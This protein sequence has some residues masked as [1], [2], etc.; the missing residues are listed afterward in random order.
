VDR[1]A[2]LQERYNLGKQNA[3]QRRRVR[4]KIMQ[5][6]ARTRPPRPVA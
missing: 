6:Q 2:E 3:A 5:L 1:L 4:G